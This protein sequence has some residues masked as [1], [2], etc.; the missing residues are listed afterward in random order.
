MPA[1]SRFGRALGLLCCSFAVLQA[2]GGRSDTE[3]FRFDDDLLPSSGRGGSNGSG[4]NSSAGKQPG[5]I[6]GT[7]MVVGGTSAGGSGIVQGGTVGFGGKATG[8]A[9]QGGVAQ[10]GVGVAGSIATGGTG[11]IVPLTCG[12]TVCNSLIET[13]CATLGGFGCIPEGEAC[14]G[15][16]LHCGAASD[17][18]GNQVCC[19]RIVDEVGSGSACKDS[20]QGMGPDRERQLCHTD[21]DCAANRQCRDTVF[22]ISVCTRF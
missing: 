10:G 13:C 15:A 3:D 4:A 5:G 16:V 20:C 2:C 22:G 11:A 21:A 12:N 18:D 19:L 17:C 8:G 6:A 1:S 7:S 14:N 9:A